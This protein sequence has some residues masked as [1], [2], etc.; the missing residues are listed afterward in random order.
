MR[1][2]EIG[3]FGVIAVVLCLLIQVAALATCVAT[4]LGSFGLLTAAMASRLTLTLSCRTGITSA[5]P[6]GLGAAVAGSVPT[7]I[8]VIVALVTVGTAVVFGRLDDDA[9]LRTVV[10]LGASVLIAIAV[11]Q[12][13]LRR[14]TRAFGG[15]TGDVLGAVTEISMTAALLTTAFIF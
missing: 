8:G 9:S 13:S 14:F 11:G 15:L 7:A 3:A 10:A 5:R 1:S 6:D 12:L 4:G 2:P